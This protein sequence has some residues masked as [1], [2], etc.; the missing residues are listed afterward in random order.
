MTELPKD[1][2]SRDVAG[3]HIAYAIYKY[4]IIKANVSAELKVSA[5]TDVGRIRF[6]LKI[7]HSDILVYIIIL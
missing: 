1:V 4:F 3:R 6:L 7:L 2:D 5:G